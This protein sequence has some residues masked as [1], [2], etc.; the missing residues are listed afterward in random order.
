MTL[1]GCNN[2]IELADIVR[3]PASKT[4]CLIF[5]FIEHVDFRSIFPKLQDYDIRFYMYELLK[6]LDY[7]HSRGIM[8]RDVKP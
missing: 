4:P 7:C 8:H 1:K 2:I 3:D 6:A 5:D